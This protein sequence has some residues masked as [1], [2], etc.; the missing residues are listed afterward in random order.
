MEQT[1]DT[2][3]LVIS[4]RSADS[5]DPLKQELV[6]RGAKDSEREAGPSVSGNYFDTDLRAVLMELSMKTGINIIPDQTVRGM[7]TVSFEKMPLEKVLRMILF[8]GGYSFKKEEGYYLVGSVDPKNP[9]T[10]RLI[11]TE[12]LRT[13]YDAKEVIESLPQMY[14][15]F[16][17]MADGIA[18]RLVINAPEHVMWKIKESIVAMDEPRKLISIDVVVAEMSYSQANSLGV[19]WDDPIVSVDGAGGLFIENGGGAFTGSLTSEF[20]LS[21]SAMSKNGSIEIRANPKIVTL[22]GETAKVQIIDEYYIPI[23]GNI[24][25]LSSSDVR[26]IDAGISLIVRPRLTRNGEILIDIEPSVSNQS[27]VSMQSAMP[28]I[29]T[30]QAK[31]T[32]KL[33]SGETFILGGLIQESTQNERKNAARSTAQSKKELVIFITPRVL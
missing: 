26:K 16:V 10:S 4:R 6:A 3:D 27:G 28:I 23:I 18:N 11:S 9:H 31:T 32:V 20:V 2:P 5:P 1:V 22:D 12:M 15:P 21:L 33:K 25:D 24:D 13:N 7:I 14:R 8:P 29:N 17:T 30:R 19:D